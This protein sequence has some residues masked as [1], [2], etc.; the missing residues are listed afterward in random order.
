MSEGDGLRALI[1]RL[2]RLDDK[3]YPVLPLPPYQADDKWYCGECNNQL[4][5]GHASGCRQLLL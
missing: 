2:K 3:G 4:A 5:K 1:K